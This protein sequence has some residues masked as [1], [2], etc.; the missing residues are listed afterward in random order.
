MGLVVGHHELHQGHQLVHGS[1][2]GGGGFVVMVVM[3]VTVT[4][5]MA[6]AVVARAVGMG[7][8]VHITGPADTGH[9]V[10]LLVGDQDVHFEIGIEQFFQL[11]GIHQAVGNLAG[12]AAVVVV[13]LFP[14]G[15]VGNGQATPLFGQGCQGGDEPLRLREMGESVVDHHIVE[16]LAEPGLLHIAADD[17]DVFVLGML[18]LRQLCHLVGD[19]DAGDGGHLSL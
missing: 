16:L 12:R 6:V 13:D 2:I 15:A 4:V 7:M 14:A 3:A 19:V 10:H 18:L 1:G 8:V 5:G 17:L 9:L 11:V